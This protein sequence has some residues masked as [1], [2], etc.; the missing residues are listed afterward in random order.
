M[1][2]GRYSRNK[3]YNTNMRKLVCPQCKV[4]A[5]YV[6]NEKGDRLSIYV[7]ENGDI[8]PKDPSESLEGFDLTDIYC[9][10]CSWHGNPKRLLKY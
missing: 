2:A 4:A 1:P 8:V 9:F 3:V 5:L 6:K 7:Y 10:G